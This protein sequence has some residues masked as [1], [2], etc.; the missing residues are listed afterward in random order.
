VWRGREREIEQVAYDG[1]GVIVGNFWWV[2]HGGSKS[3][4]CARFGDCATET[5]PCN[6][7][8]TFFRDTS[9]RGERAT[10]WPPLPTPAIRAAGSAATVALLK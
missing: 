3:R 9:N 1:L 7:L 4:D 8:F 6:V 10:S 5:Y 2:V